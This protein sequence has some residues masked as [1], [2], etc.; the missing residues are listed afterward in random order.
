MPIT[1]EHCGACCAWVGVPPFDGDEM[2]D[3][4]VAEIMDA[5]PQASER[6]TKQFACSAY[7]MVTASCRI[8]ANRPKV[9]QSFV[10]G[11]TQC[12]AARARFNLI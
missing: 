9:C 12:Q 2:A 5:I 10:P 1:C 7:D 8:Y 11:S 3:P 6:V 4:A